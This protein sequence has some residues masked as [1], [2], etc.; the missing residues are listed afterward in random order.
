MHISLNW[1]KDFVSIPELSPQEIATR[2]TL[3]T[4]EVEGVEASGDGL[5]NVIIV[6]IKSIKP[7]PEADKLN[8][9]T[10][11]TGKGDFEVVCGAGNVKVGMK[12]YFAPIGSTLPNGLKL[13]AK[14]IRGILSQG[15]LCSST[16]LGLGEGVDGLLELPVD[17]P[18]GMTFFEHRQIKP[19]I[20]LEVDNKSLTHRPDLWGHYGLAREFA[21]SFNQKLK[22]P[23]TKEWENKIISNFGKGAGPIQ[24][25]V[26]SSSACWAYLGLNITGITVSESPAWIQE[27]LNAVGL[28]PINSIVDISNYVMV[29]LGMPNHIFDADKIQ[30]KKL[31]IKNL[32]AATS[33]MT[34]DENTRELIESD[35]VIC[36][37]KSVSV[38]AGIMGGKDS[39]VSAETKNIFLEVAN[40]DP[41]LVRKTSVRLGLRSDSSQRFEKTLDSNL[42]HRSMLRLV[43]LILELNPNAKIQ[44]ELQSWYNEERR[45]K[46]LTLEFSRS[47]I[48]KVLGE[49]VTSEKLV[50]YFESLDFTVVQE[51]D[52]FKVTVP[53][54]RTTKDISCVDD[55]VEEIGRLIGY[56]NIVPV[57]PLLPVNPI[58]L[59]TEKTMQRKLQDFLV[60]EARCL[61]IMTY[62]LV[63]ED[64]LK[65]SRWPSDINKLKLVNAISVEQDRM[66]PSLIP[67]A[68]KI[69]SENAK[70]F[71]DFSFFE[72]GRSYQDYENERSSVL[73]GFYS[74]ESNRF[75]EL[76]N[77]VEK[78]LTYLGL[79][80]SLEERN[81]KFP[82]SI[83]PYEWSG[84]HPHE[85]VNMRIQ[86][87]FHGAAT[88]IH[89]LLLKDFKMKGNLCVAVI[90]LTDFESRPVK[91]KTKYTPIS[92][93]PQSVF[94]ISVVAA[95]EVAAGDVLKTLSGLKLKELKSSSVLTIFDLPE[96]KK[97]VTLRV[98]FEDPTATMSA[99]FL[100]NAEKQVVQVLEKAGFPLR[101]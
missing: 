41:S 70:H 94:D 67:S 79:P 82:N 10:F 9:V 6:Q 27:R 72:F 65:K 15:M 78:L 21:A 17:A 60:L 71:S 68:L 38:L 84:N 97:S 28:R 35:T 89:P 39:G 73:I 69:A 18:V 26:D 1:I 19:D 93:F 58:R 81:L 76:L 66:R 8:L 50:N 20:I 46:P 91:D 85:Y 83:I 45:S 53:S 90:D 30:G 95:K 56:D 36:D 29:E 51:R 32:G 23:F 55:L 54:W 33:F 16:E 5:K 77:T 92:R 42:C 12:V 96:E 100:A 99:E 22:T 80:V 43:E 7:H 24:F 14:K 37:D 44:G 88:T 57:S 49:D 13:E 48:T 52:Q 63:G 62:P 34:L 98:V 3:T 61:E 101:A 75:L 25:T 40:W 47:R 31:T 11:D 74:R 4:A 59:S 86:G 87:K 64:L 2:F